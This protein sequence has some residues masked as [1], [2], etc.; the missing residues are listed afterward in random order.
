MTPFEVHPRLLKSS[1]ELAQRKSCHVLL[2]DNSHF[3]WFLIVPEVANGEEDLHQLTEERA[4]EVMSLVR[5]VSQFVSEYFQP[6]KLNV[7]CIGNQVRQMHL[8]VVG[9]TPHDPAWPGVVWSCDAK[10]PYTSER[11]SEIR[12]AF[13]ERL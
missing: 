7:A 2:K 10:Q 8:H 13:L 3:P 5:E 6:E 1:F 12:S 9:R 11:V 4:A